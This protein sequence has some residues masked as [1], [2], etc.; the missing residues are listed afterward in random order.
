[1]KNRLKFIAA[2]LVCI[3]LSNP[4]AFG[5]DL[6]PPTNFFNESGALLDMTDPIGDDKGPGYY[7]YPLDSR[8]PRGTYDLKRF[9]VYEEGNVIVFVI[10]MREFILT[11]FPKSR[12]GAEQGFV[13]QTFDIYLDLDRKKGSGYTKALPGRSVE[14]G[15]EMGWEKMILIT[16]LSQ[17]RVYDM[18]KEKTDDL[19]FQ[20]TIPDIIIP[21]YVQVQADRLI[22][23]INRDLIGA[24]ASPKW[25]Y[26]CFVMG[27]SP[28][29]SSNQVLNKDV[30]A[31][32]TAQDFGGGWDTYGDPPIMDC[33]VPEGEDQYKLLNDFRS[34]P[35]QENIQ[36]TRLPFVYPE[37]DP[38]KDVPAITPTAS[39]GES[40][41]DRKTQIA[42]PPVPP[43]PGIVSPPTIVTTVETKFSDSY[44]LQPPVIFS[45]PASKQVNPAKTSP[46]GR[47]AGLG[48]P[49][50]PSFTDDKPETGIFIPV[51]KPVT[52]VVKKPGAVKKTVSA[53]SGF[54]PVNKKEI[55][56]DT[57]EEGFFMVA[58]PA[59]G[60]I[61]VSKTK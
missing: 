13:A 59:P 57:A 48:A 31:F 44:D 8:L 35:Y 51:R 1:M 54:I 3:L 55:Q 9:T 47:F 49:G 25:G 14:F 46:S 4:P 50:T 16:P 42:R 33:I 21:D 34:E 41:S 22:V 56:I 61:K 11:H 7:Q 20:D 38:K 26:Q 18:L 36:F 12:D 10:K 58:Q 40:F 15:N 17:F 37:W 30:K 32:S 27:F 6:R 43:A 39:K 29:V 60:F 28:L 5:A 52:T 45:Q 53:K 23:R 2:I 24:K 19:A